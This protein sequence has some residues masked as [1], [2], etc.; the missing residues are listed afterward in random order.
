MSHSINSVSISGGENEQQVC[1]PDERPDKS[2]ANADSEAIFHE[3]EK[4]VLVPSSWQ[5]AG[6]SATLP[7]NQQNELYHATDVLHGYQMG[8]NDEPQG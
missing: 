2:R 8:Q 6:F 7:A 4:G 3:T 1:R 5:D